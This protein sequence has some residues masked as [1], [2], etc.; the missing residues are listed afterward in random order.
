[1]NPRVLPWIFHFFGELD[2]NLSRWKCPHLYFILFIL[3]LGLKRLIERFFFKYIMTKPRSSLFEK[4]PKMLEAARRHFFAAA[5]MEAQTQQAYK[6]TEDLCRCYYS[7]LGRFLD[8][9]LFAL[10]MVSQVSQNST[11]SP[12]LAVC[13]PMP[14]LCRMFSMFTSGCQGRTNT[15]R[16]VSH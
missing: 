7:S 6:N 16:S 14:T 4:V 5:E 12:L 9:L 11:F 1:M 3:F 8:L 13:P 2:E 15:W 10:N